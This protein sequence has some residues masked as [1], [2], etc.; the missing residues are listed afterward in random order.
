METFDTTIKNRYGTLLNTDIKLHRQWFKEFVRLHG[1]KVIYRAVKDG[2]K[3]TNYA[4][5]D[6]NFESPLLEGC[7]FDE[8][9]TQQTLKKMG[10]MSELQDSSSIIHVRYDLPGIQQGCL[11]IIPSGLDNAKGRLFRVVKLT[12]G[13]VYP[14]TITCEIVPEYESTFD[15][16]SHNH[17]YSSFNLL[18]EEDGY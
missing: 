8:H 4:E 12:N 15:E 16:S 10:W 13:I 18:E 6:T 9:P 5:L 3:Y 1:I 11:F 7:I 2:K 14:A 17:D